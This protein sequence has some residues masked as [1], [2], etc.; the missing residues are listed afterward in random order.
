MNN[1][2]ENNL[3]I[4]DGFMKQGVGYAVANAGKIVATITLVVAILTTFTNIT[5]T[6]F[7]SE[8]FSITLTVILLS[9]YVIYFSMEDVGERE[10]METKEHSEANKKFLDARSRIHPDDIEGLRSFCLLYSEDELK[11]RRQNFLC[12]NGLTI[13][14][15]DKYNSGAVY[16]KR[17]L[18]IFRR[19]NAMKAVRLTAASLL[20]SSHRMP[21]SEL[22]S[23]ERS[24]MLSTCLS[25]VPSTLCSIF[26]VSIILTTKSELTVSTVIDGLIKLSALPMV[27][28]KGFLDGYRY[29]KNSKTCWLETKTRVIEAFLSETEK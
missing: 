17:L 3:R 7:K 21:E 16:P 26:T 22:T 25:L 11:Y 19:A 28:F 2:S 29:S 9:S 13:A 6:N 5:F 10:G 12:E 23:P 15:L 20:S 1:S 14:D 8:A 18:R 27:G 4:L 24:K